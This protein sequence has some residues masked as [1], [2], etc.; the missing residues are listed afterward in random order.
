MSKYLIIGLS[1][2]LFASCKIIQPNKMFQVPED[3]DYAKFKEAQKEYIIQPYDKLNMRVFTNDGIDMLNQNAGSNTGNINTMFEYLVEHDG[4]VNFPVIG[5][6]SIV[7]QT[8]KQAEKMLEEM[9]S[10]Y[11]QKPFVKVAVTNRRVSV[12]SGGSQ[13]GKVIYLTEENFNLIE[14][15]A[16]SGGISDISKAYNIKLIRGDLNNPEI[17]LFDLTSFNN[18]EN[19]NFLL[20]ANDI[21]Y[22]ETKPRY[23]SRIFTEI[24]PYLSLLTSIILISQLFK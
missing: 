16:Q 12:F 14:A 3:Y 13:V 15:L 18:F 4:L 22:V 6:I 21:I 24:S 19:V 11:Y 5:R 7:G 23:A 17:Y 2:V 1:I 8:V 10:A 9:Y 20:E